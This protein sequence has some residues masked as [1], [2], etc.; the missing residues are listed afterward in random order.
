M[1]VPAFDPAE[2]SFAP[3]KDPVCL[4]FVPGAK[5]QGTGHRRQRQSDKI[6][7]QNDNDY[8]KG[9][10]TKDDSGNSF[11]KK[12]W[13]KNGYNTQ[14]RCDYGHAHLRGS[15]NRSNFRLL[16]RVLVP[17]DI[18]QHYNGIIHYH[19]HRDGKTHQRDDIERIAHGKQ[20]DEGHHDRERDRQCHDQAGAKASEEQKAND[21][22]Q[23]S[24]DS[25][26]HCKVVDHRIN[27]VGCVEDGVH[28]DVR[29]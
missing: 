18:F 4:P 27:V 12:E 14:C 8:H 6:G 29:G 3:D 5:Q 11:D 13:D 16:P 21:D 20:P 22:D 7:C 15:C 26:C 10:L 1:G 2:Y 25:G 24:A 28:L 19:S 17:D 23:N 9:Q